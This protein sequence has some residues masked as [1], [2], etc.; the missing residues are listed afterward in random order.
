[1]PVRCIAMKP[2]GGAGGFEGGHALGQQ[3]CCQTGQHIA[4]TCGGKRR[5]GVVVDHGAAIGAG[6]HRVAAFENDDGA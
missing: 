4:G 6:D 1:M 5:R 2:H 3:A